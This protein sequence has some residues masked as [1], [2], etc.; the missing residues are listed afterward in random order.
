MNDDVY[1]L[2]VGILD[3]LLWDGDLI[4]EANLPKNEPAVFVANHLAT[5]GPIGATCTLPMRIYPWIV[6]DM[7]D[8]EKAA[9]YLLWDFIERTL[10]LNPR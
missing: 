4:G 7:V 2:I 1:H 5:S 9:E 8:R 3:R 6:A 10:R